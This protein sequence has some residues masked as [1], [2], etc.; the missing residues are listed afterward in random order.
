MAPGDTGE[1]PSNCAVQ[2]A[3]TPT[4]TGSKKPGNENRGKTA[5]R[6][7]AAVMR[8]SVVRM[9]ERRQPRLQPRTGG[10][11]GGLQ[12]KISEA[13]KTDWAARASTRRAAS[14]PDSVGDHPPE[15]WL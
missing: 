5:N 6:K 10:G 1:L 14:H 9:R 15:D 8:T 11:R 3:L 7:M 13:R 4:P 2:S 12:R